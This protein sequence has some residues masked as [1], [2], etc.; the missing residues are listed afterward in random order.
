MRAVRGSSTRGARRI[1]RRCAL[2]LNNLCFSGNR[3]NREENEAWLRKARRDLRGVLAEGEGNIAPGLQL[4]WDGRIAEAV[5]FALSLASNGPADR[6][7]QAR[8][9]SL[10][11]VLREIFARHHPF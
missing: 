10:F 7:R 4:R 3:V 11:P 6:F 2:L 5:V 1:L 8:A 9:T